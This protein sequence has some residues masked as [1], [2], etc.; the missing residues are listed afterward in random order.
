MKTRQFVA[1]EVKRFISSGVMKTSTIS[2]KQLAA[3]F[4]TSISSMY[5]IVNDLVA[6]S[7]IS[8]EHNKFVVVNYK[9][10]T[11]RVLSML[12]KIS[13][14][15]KLAR[16]SMHGSSIVGPWYITKVKRSARIR[17]VVTNESFMLS[18]NKIE[19]HLNPELQPI[20]FHIRKTMGMN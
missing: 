17:N 2:P 20:E 1:E 9:S 15:V 6:E 16:V 12:A 10:T 18:R 8:K 14:S 3:M 5:L 4:G 19:H 7:I 13:A 11:D